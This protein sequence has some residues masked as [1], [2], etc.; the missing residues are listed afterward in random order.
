MELFS[1]LRIPVSTEKNEWLV[2]GLKNTLVEPV[3][4][5]ETAMPL[6][7]LSDM[8]IGSLLV[9]GKVNMALF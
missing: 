8:I 2:R 5:G 6:A 4:T 1:F 9:P 3:S 7:L